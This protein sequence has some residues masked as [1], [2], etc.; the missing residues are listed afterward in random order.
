MGADHDD[1]SDRAGRPALQL[2]PPGRYQCFHPARGDL[3]RRLDASEAA[4]AAYARALELA[5][6]SAERASQER[7][8]GLELRLHITLGSRNARA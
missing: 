2:G 7:R 1:P 8:L 6:N 3:L 5:G 4:A